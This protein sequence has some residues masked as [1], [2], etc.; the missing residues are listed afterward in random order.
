M[1]GF[2]RSVPASKVQVDDHATHRSG[3]LDSL[4]VA[5][6]SGALIRLRIGAGH[7]TDWL[8]KRNYTFQR[9]IT[10]ATQST[11]PEGK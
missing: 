4:R 5:E 2:M 3:L 1:E 6:V 10:D 7:V 9:R 11:D 8:P